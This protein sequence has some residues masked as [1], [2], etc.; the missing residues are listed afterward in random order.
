M[1]RR[2]IAVAVMVI[3]ATA[4]AWAQQVR[5]TPPTLGPGAPPDI[6]NA[7]E[8]ASEAL[9]NSIDGAISQYFNLPLFA[10]GIADSGATSTHIG[11]QRAF[12]DYTRFAVVV[13]TGF[14]ASLPSADLTLLE[15]AV[16]QLEAGDLYFGA[17]FQ[18]VVASI[19]FRPRFISDRLYMNA[20]FGY[21]DVSDI[22]GAEGFSYNAMSVG[23]LANYR[24]IE[25]RSLPLGFIRWRGVTVGSGVTYQRNELKVD[26]DFDLEPV[27][28]DDHGGPANYSLALAPVLTAIATSD[29][30]V[31]PLEVT[32]GLRLLW[33]FDFN[34]GA[35]VDLSFGTS[36][37][38]LAIN[39]PVVLEGDTDG[40]EVTPGSA[41]VNAGTSGD[42][43][44]FVR[45]RLTGGFGL[46]F[47]PVK[48]DVPMMYYFDQDGNS[49]MAGVN[50]GIVF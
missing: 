36:D 10:Q 33:L 12:I 29:S 42:G 44:A 3:A 47:G 46:N 34:I 5:I 19:G 2:L 8:A 15:S 48:I 24:L 39:S 4:G 41:N 32:T 11:T 30:V 14:S 49:F 21:S 9:E 50:V 25:S 16:S 13:G 31:V 7:L 38:S 20:K 23:L 28:L 1:T 22:P 17:G 37:V 43:P 26:L 40:F 27:E 6:V 35:G 18:P 45:P